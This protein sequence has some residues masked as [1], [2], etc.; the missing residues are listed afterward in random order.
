MCDHLK[1]EATVRVGR[2]TDSDDQTKITGYMTDIT[3]H[4]ADCFKP[5]QWVGVPGGYSPNQPMVSADGTE[6]RAPIKPII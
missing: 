3:V 4:C 1:F 2:L 5:F 6:L